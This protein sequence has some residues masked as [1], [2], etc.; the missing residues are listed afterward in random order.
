VELY[1]QS[2]NTPSWRGA[3]LNHGKNFTFTFTFTYE[4]ARREELYN[5]LIEYGILMTLVGLIKICLKETYTKVHIGKNLSA[6]PTQ[7]DLEK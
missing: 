7:N 3:Q 6:F 1:V 2:H 5:I 4:S